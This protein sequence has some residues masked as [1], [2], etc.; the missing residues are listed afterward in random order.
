MC[1]NKETDSTLGIYRNEITRDRLTI[2]GA[3]WKK[4]GSYFLGVGCLYFGWDS[5]FL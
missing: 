4:M 2:K 5:Y 3:L 1:E